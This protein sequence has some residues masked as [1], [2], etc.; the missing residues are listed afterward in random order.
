MYKLFSELALVYLLLNP[1]VVLSYWGGYNRPDHNLYFLASHSAKGMNLGRSGQGNT[2]GD[3]NPWVEAQLEVYVASQRLSVRTTTATTSLDTTC[4]NV[5]LF[6]IQNPS[7]DNI[8]CTLFILEQVLNMVKLLS[9]PE[10]ALM[11][12]N[13]NPVDNFVGNPVERL[14]ESLH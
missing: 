2:S 6:S 5:H 12:A 4:Q 10:T 11:G 3:Q 13:N 9:S 7:R 1:E 8:L 14:W